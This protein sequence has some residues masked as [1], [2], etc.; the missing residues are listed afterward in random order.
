MSAGLTPDGNTVDGKTR[1]GQPAY[2]HVIAQFPRE[3]LAKWEIPAPL[4]Q[5]LGSGGQSGNVK[6][7]GAIM[8]GQSHPLSQFFPSL[9]A[10]QLI[11]PYAHR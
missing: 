3:E 5:G 2:D 10:A 11:Y 6:D 8:D 4:L 7:Y 1:S 9:A